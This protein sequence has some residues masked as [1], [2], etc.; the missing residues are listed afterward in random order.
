[1]KGK[2]NLSQHLNP[3][4][5]TCCR[6]LHHKIDE[7][8]PTTC[9]HSLKLQGPSEELHGWLTNCPF[10]CLGQFPYYGDSYQTRVGGKHQE[11]IVSSSVANCA[12]R[13]PKGSQYMSIT[14]EFYKTGE[15][16]TAVVCV[17]EK[18]SP[19]H[20]LFATFSTYPVQAVKEVWFL[21]YDD[22]IQASIWSF[23]LPPTGQNWICLWLAWNPRI[24]IFICIEVAWWHYG[25][26]KMTSS[27]EFLHI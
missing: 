20:S 11:T 9:A 14:S 2:F 6:L 7:L 18:N 10:T 16:K 22:V 19:T 24:K 21:S 1:M 4:P 3:S 27:Q 26:L 12:S 15:I 5:S 25:G 23:S 17:A 8:L 13:Q